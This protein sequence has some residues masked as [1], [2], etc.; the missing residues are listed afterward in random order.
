MALQPEQLYTPGATQTPNL[1]YFPYQDGIRSG[2]LAA[3]SADAE[4]AHGL[5]LN[6]SQSSGSW[7]VFDDDG[8]TA[9]VNVITAAATT[10]TD[11][12]FTLTVEGQTTAPIDHAAN[13]AAIRAAIVALGYVNGDVTVVDGGGGI[14]ANNG[15]A[16]ITFA[17]TGALSGPVSI[18][19]DFS[20]LTGNV[21]VLSE[22]TPGTLGSGDAIE[23][24]L[25]SPEKPHQGLNAGETIINVFRRGLVHADDIPLP[26]GVSRSSVESAL[27][28]AEVRKLGLE[29]QGLPGIG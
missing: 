4:L 25:W 21:H 28:S 2:R 10:A 13:A 12:T 18:T 11:G 16:T 26:A 27:R 5:P 24:F 15:T 1:R 22:T 17:N 29:I 19:A 9:Q 6:F 8:G 7:S 14:A 3:L 23:G 20:G